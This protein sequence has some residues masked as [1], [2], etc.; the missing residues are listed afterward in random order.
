MHPLRT[1]FSTLLVFVGAI[2]TGE[3]LAAN[4]V[5]LVVGNSAYTR[6]GALANPI[7]DATDVA[8]VLKQKG[9]AVIEGSNLDK[10]NF[11]SK[12]EEF[13]RAASGAEIA[14]FFYAGHG[15]Q[16]AGR[17]FLVP[18]D[19]ELDTAAAIDTQL[20]TASF[21]YRHMERGARFK[22]VVLD[23]CRDNPLAERL[24]AS[25]GER[26]DEIGRGLARED[27][28]LGWD[29]LISFSTQ[30][31]NVARD[32][33]GRNSP[34]THALVGQ[35]TSVD[36]NTDLAK[37]LEGVRRDVTKA[38]RQAQIPWDSSSLRV[39]VFLDR[40]TQLELSDAA[41]AWPKV[42]RRNLVELEAFIGRYPTS[43]EAD[44]A[45]ARLRVPTCI[46]FRGNKECISV[47]GRP[48]TAVRWFKDCPH[49]PE[50][51][52]VP[53]GHLQMG[54]P[55]TE[56]GRG[57]GEDQVGITIP[58]YF[59]AGRSKVTTSEWNACV[60]GGGCKPIDGNAAETRPAEVPLHEARAYAKWVSASTGKTYRLLSEAEWEYVM[61]AGTTSA[62]WWGPTIDARPATGVNNPWSIR[63]D[64]LEWVE[65]CWNDS[66]R[67][68]PADGR[69]RTTGDCARQ[70]VRGGKDEDPSTL[71]SGY[72][73]S[74]PPDA[75]GIGFRVVS[76]IV[77]R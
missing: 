67:G 77:D 20:V 30:P 49:C 70:V 13:G 2:V 58:S 12:I 11:V 37:I 46:G 23:A 22:I 55:G 7:N 26:S 9:F 18:I 48:T 35:L 72:R 4:R 71:R 39:P 74:A 17:N 52:V 27:F 45:R 1:L 56:A 41:R 43:A 69:A 31:G 50:M 63:A 66:I 38:T 16:I 33:D 65:D 47:A 42:D 68:I 10:A 25:L 14:L 76:T 6:A 3:A 24:K 54:S 64:G 73:S 60:A 32:G 34:F 36:A 44:Q 61:R 19:A 53:W 15:L 75:K 5:A 29:S 28:Q 21:V 51:I 59:A 57:P 62:F 8:G 40:A